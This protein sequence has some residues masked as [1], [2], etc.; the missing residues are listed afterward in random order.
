[1][2]MCK[3]GNAF[4]ALPAESVWAKGNILNWRESEMDWN[5]GR[6]AQPGQF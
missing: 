3:N 5:N 4:V 1:M 2:W 6:K